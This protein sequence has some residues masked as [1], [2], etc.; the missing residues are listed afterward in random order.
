MSGQPT[1][2]LH[3]QLI[4][5]SLQIICQ[6]VKLDDKQKRY[7]V[8]SLQ[9]HHRGPAHVTASR[10]RQT[11]Y[12]IVLLLFSVWRKKCLST[13]DWCS[14][15]T[16]CNPPS[17]ASISGLY[18][19]LRGASAVC[20]CSFACSEASVTRPISTK[21]NSQ[22]TRQWDAENI[23]HLSHAK[24][25]SFV[26]LELSC[27]SWLWLLTSYYVFDWSL[28]WYSVVIYT[29]PSPHIDMST[30]LAHL[31]ASKQY[32]NIRYFPHIVWPRTN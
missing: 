7:S 17:L 3:S 18:S 25:S 1:R 13:R 26:W 29:F 28:S 12:W 2:W 24:F 19:G 9:S 11:S 20:S 31:D 27:P 16:Y 23:S 8:G 4:I 6:P 15:S 30:L 14:S 10:A 22:I 21:N 32:K 5:C